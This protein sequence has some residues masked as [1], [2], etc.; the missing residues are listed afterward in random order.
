MKRRNLYAAG[1]AL[2]A[3][4]LAA[5][6]ANGQRRGA[7]AAR[8]NANASAADVAL[9]ASDAAAV[10]DLRRLL[11]EAV[12][13]ALASDPARLAQVNADLDRFKTQTGIDPRAF[14]RVTAGARFVNTSAGGFK[15]GHV[16]ALADGTFDAAAL[17]AAARTAAGG[18]HREERHGGKTVHVFTVSQRVKLFGVLPEMN[19][20]EFALCPLDA[21]TVAVGELA[22][23]RAAVDAAAGRGRVSAALLALARQNPSA[24]VGFG[25]NAP[26]ALARAAAGLGGEVE[27]SL[28]SIRQFYGSVGTTQA[29]FDLLIGARTPTAADA[30]RLVDTLKAL[31]SLGDFAA[32]Q[33]TGARGEALRRALANV[34]LEPQGNDALIRL[35]VPSADVLGLFGTP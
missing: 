34:R 20:R 2:V 5:D 30:R 15:V 24:L 10:V 6:A 13:R 12:P 9:P 32:A 25:A 17:V 27:R 11:N 29:G 4:A 31:K 22:A 18:S 16:V 21:D 28:A 8:T 23:V 1:L 35:D 33:R 3:L 19:V 14:E 26:P 7:G